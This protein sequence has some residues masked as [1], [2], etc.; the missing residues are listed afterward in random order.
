[1]TKHYHLLKAYVGE[2]A[3]DV[4]GRSSARRMTG[5]RFRDALMAEWNVIVAEVNSDFVY[6]ARDLGVSLAAAGIA[7]VEQRANAIITQQFGPGAANIAGMFFD[8]LR[9]SAGAPKGP[10]PPKK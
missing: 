7:S 3:K 10:V 4:I 8:A 1:M 5:E 6:L 2:V 9:Q